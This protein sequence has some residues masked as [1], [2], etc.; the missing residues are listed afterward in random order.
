MPLEEGRPFGWRGLMFEFKRGFDGPR[1]EPAEWR[2]AD[3][4]IKRQGRDE[5]SLVWAN[6][7]GSNGS[8]DNPE[9]ALEAAWKALY[10]RTESNAEFLESLT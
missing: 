8:G 4:Y 6:L 5:I 1:A 10:T 9:A 2:C 7:R 3:G